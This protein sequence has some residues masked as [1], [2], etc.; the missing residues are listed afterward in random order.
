[1]NAP[2]EAGLAPL[3]AGRH[4]RRHLHAHPESR[5]PLQPAVHRHDRRARRGARRR[6][7]PTRRCASSC[8][9]ARGRAFCAG[10]DLTEM[11][12]HID[13]EWQR[14]LFD[15]C[16]RMM[17]KLTQ[18][19]AAGDRARPGRGRG[20]GVPARVDVR[21]R[22]RRR[23]RQVRPVRHQRRH[24][25]HDAGGGRRPQR[26]RA[27]ARWS[28]CSPASSSTRRPRS[29]WGLVNRVVP[30]RGA[31]RG[32]GMRSPRPSR[33]RAP[34]SSRS[35]SARST[36]RSSRGIAE[37][38]RPRRRDDGLQHARPRR[39]RRHRR[40]SRQA[41]AALALAPSNAAVLAQPARNPRPANRRGARRGFDL[42]QRGCRRA[43]LNAR[44]VGLAGAKASQ[45]T[46]RGEP[47]GR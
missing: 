35:A 23:S 4:A 38:L 18:H 29:T 46:R 37:R 9:P 39:R 20:R 31:R 45:R 41:S 17:L 2:V 27:S 28:S 32:R 10:H 12:A 36:R 21:S 13:H 19:S 15:A 34:P 33:A 22:G 26:R 14:E 30:G 1:M 47:D 7:R 44:D 3:R 24:L 8:S 16:T 11:R 5:R 43:C 40:V 6:R 42:R 25:L